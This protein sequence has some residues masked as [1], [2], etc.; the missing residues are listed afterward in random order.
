L[1]WLGYCASMDCTRAM[2]YG[3]ARVV[4]AFFRPEAA[5]G[6]RPE[7]PEAFTS[8]GTLAALRD[9]LLTH[10]RR[11]AAE[12]AERFVSAVA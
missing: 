5:A 4:R 2:R 1:T 9:T 11:A 3:R 7:G 10:L 12:N 8:P 6:A